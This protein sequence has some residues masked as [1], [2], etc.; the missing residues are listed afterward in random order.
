MRNAALRYRVI[1][2]YAAAFAIAWFFWFVMSR[3]YDGRQPSPFVYLFSTL[4][5]LAPLIGM[6][7][8]ERLTHKEVSLPGNLSQIRLRGTR[9]L[10]FLLAD[11]A[12]PAITLLGI[13]GS[14]LLDPGS[15][16]R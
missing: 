16:L 5:G 14:H 10:W 6:A 15:A 13:V 9:A 11:F 1:I 3:V 12:L 8:L 4:G 7:V 2:F